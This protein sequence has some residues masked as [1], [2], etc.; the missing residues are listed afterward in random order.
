[1][2]ASTTTLLKNR[3]KETYEDTP[4]VR[5]FYIG[6]EL[7]DGVFSKEN[8]DNSLANFFVILFGPW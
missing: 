2:E 3:L 1:M 6:V 8:L 5:G 7:D 4:G